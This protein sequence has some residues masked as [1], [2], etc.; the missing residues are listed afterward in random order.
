MARGFHGGRK[1]EGSPFLD[2]LTMQIQAA[3]VE[4][5]F[6][7]EHRKKADDMVVGLGQGIGD[8]VAPDPV[9]RPAPWPRFRHPGGSGW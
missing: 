8:Q 7:T 6:Q 1:H 4:G 3:N 9:I 5:Q 2:Q